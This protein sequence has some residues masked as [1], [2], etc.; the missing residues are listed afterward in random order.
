MWDLLQ[1]LYCTYQGPNPLNCADVARDFGRHCTVGTASW[2]LLSLEHDVDTMLRNI[3][4]FGL[5]MFSGDIS[6]SINHFLKHGHNE[7]SNQGGGGG[8]C[9]VERVDEVSGRQWSAI[10][11]E[12]NVQA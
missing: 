7:R 10:H 3:K 6:E 8:G 5:G 1:A 2:Y 12:A 4:P 9:R 11:T